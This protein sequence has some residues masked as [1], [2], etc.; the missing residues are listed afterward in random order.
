MDGRRPP[1]EMSNF[2]CLPGRAGGTPIGLDEYEK[3]VLD[4]ETPHRS[5]IVPPLF[6]G[7]ERTTIEVM[8]GL[9]DRCLEQFLIG[10]GICCNIRVRQG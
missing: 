5:F 9:F 4:R 8:R 3:I 7:S 1:P 2:Y 10:G 6:E